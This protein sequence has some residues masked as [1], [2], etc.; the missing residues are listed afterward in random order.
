MMFSKLSMRTK[1]FSV[2]S[3]LFVTMTFMGIFSFFQLRAINETTQDIQTNWLPSVRWL[4]ELRVQSARYRAILRDHILITEPKAK[5]GIDKNLEDRI[6]EYN[7][8]TLK[9]QDLITSPEERALFNELTKLW[10]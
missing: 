3:F 2:V 5:A 7:N 9:Y 1:I 6:K 4:S 8:A 10:K